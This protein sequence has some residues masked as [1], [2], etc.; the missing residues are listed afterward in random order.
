M[1]VDVRPDEHIEPD[2]A[3]ALA[4]TARACALAGWAFRRVG[5]IDP[6]LL[7]NVRWLAGYRHPRNHREPAA[8]ELT[9]AFA[10]PGGLLAGAERVGDRLAVLPVLYH[11]LWRR[12][13]EANLE[14]G[15]LGPRSMVRRA[16]TAR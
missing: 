14:S 16:V 6:V 13:L 3:E 8:S 9:A 2:D 4:A 11:L 10:Q 5:A 15:V 7:A 12:I 1:V